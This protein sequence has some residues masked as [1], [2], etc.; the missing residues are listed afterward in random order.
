M[1]SHHAKQNLEVNDYPKVTVLL[2]TLN[3]ASFLDE[4]L[5]SLSQQQAVSIEVY[6]NDDGS[7][8]GTLGVLESWREKGLIVSLSHSRGKGST[9]A[10]LDLLQLCGEKKYVAFCDQD[11]IWDLNKLS[12]QIAACSENSPVLVFS[13]RRYI[14]SL[15]KITG[16]SLRPNKALSFESAL[17]EN[18][19]PGNTV[20]LNSAAINVINS[21]TSP[22]VAHYDSWIYL[23][24]SAFGKCHYVDLP[25]VNYRIHEN[26]QVGLRKLRFS[27]V[28]ASILSFLNQAEYLSI[29]SE[30]SLTESQRLIL[31]QFTSLLSKNGEK[32]KLRNSLKVRIIRQRFIDEIGLR[33]VLFYLIAKGKI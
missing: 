11:D 18:I 32:Q 5:A 16:I 22:E 19:A 23:L 31:T 29:H 33:L 8:D 26:N 30:R 1:I 27:F 24:I 9:K 10:F 15:G 7:T 20:L 14:D 3:G 17:C 6:V 4:Q 21:Y 12:I 28:Q 13:R 25:L 2:T